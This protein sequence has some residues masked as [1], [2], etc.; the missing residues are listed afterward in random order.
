[1][2]NKKLTLLTAFSMMLSVAVVVSFFTMSATSSRPLPYV[3][4]EKL[5]M[6]FEMTKELRA[7]LELTVNQRKAILDSLGL[8]LKMLAEEVSRSSKQNEN[9]RLYLNHLQEQYLQ[10]KQEFEEDNQALT[11]KYDEQIWTRINL[12]AKA[13]GEKEGYDYIYGANGNGSILYAKE[14][15]DVTDR[16]LKYINSEY[17]G[18]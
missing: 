16:V 7:N 18:L 6:D 4:S 14:S 15:L 17:K 11:N 3:V 10:K 5:F 13:F 2:T 12:Y 9:Q 8:N 1:M